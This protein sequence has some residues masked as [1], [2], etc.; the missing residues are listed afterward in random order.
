[1]FD[2]VDRPWIDVNHIA[3]DLTVI[4]AIVCLH[5]ETVDGPL[6]NLVDC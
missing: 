5:D 3:D 1:M 4:A 2:A 6:D